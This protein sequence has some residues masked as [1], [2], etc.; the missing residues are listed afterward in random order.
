ML[1]AI[2]SVYGMDMAKAMLEVRDERPE[3]GNVKIHGY[4]TQPVITKSDR[5]GESFFVNGRFVRNMLLSR[6][7][8]DA[9]RTLIP[10]GKYPI[11]VIFVDVD[12]AEIDVNVHPTKREVKFAK[13]DVV[14]RAASHQLCHRLLGSYSWRIKAI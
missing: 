2:A 10:N 4:V 7:L 9:Y 12:P 1:D 11:A 14:M 5:Y 13:P 3:T 8:E 6:A